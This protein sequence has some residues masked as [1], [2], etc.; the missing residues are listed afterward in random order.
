MPK[1]EIPS[2]DFIKRVKE[3]TKNPGDVFLSTW[4]VK[5]LAEEYDQEVVGDGGECVVIPLEDNERDIVAAFTYK[6]MS[7]ITAKNIFYSQR[8]LSTLFP[9]NFPHFYAAFGRKKDKK[10]IT[11]TIRERIR[12]N[13][14]REIK[15]SFREI[16]EKL[17]E[18]GLHFDFDSTKNDNF[19]IGED[20]GEYYVD[21]S[22]PFMYYLKNLKMEGLVSYMQENG[23][24][25]TD[26]SIVT[27]SIK[28]LITLAKELETK[29]KAPNGANVSTGGDGGN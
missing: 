28:R 2:N 16:E 14:K 7:S 13:K 8:I 6:E 21:V 1:L 17:A 25:E 29:T 19:I 11:G 26:I 15:Y 23:Y 3:K 12:N 22:L 24:S 20:G 9:H 18:I 27:T 4:E 5:K 10:N